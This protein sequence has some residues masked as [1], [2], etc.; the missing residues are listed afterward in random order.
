VRSARV[1]IDRPQPS[2]FV[3]NDDAKPKAS[4]KLDMK[5]GTRLS[6]RQI[7]GIVH[8]TAGAIAGLSPDRVEIMDGSGLLTAKNGDGGAM[9]AQTTLD[10]EAARETYL[11]R[12][13]QDLLDAT[14]GPGRSSVKVSL[15]MDF[16]KRSTATSDPTKSVM[17]RENTTTTD[18]KTPVLPSGGVVGTAPNVEGDGAGGGGKTAMGSKTK[19]EVKNEYVVG[20][21]T[22]TQEDEVGRIKG[23]TVSILLDYKTVKEPKKDDK[24]NPTKEMEEKRIEYTEAERKRFSDLVLN[25]IG[26]NAAKGLAAGSGEAA[27]VVESR[28]SVSVQSMELWREPPEETVVQAGVSLLGNQIKWLDFAG[29][30][31]VGIVALGFLMVAR[32]Q[33][34]RSHKAWSDAEAR[35]R[36]QAE[37]EAARRKT[38]EAAESESENTEIDDQK[39]RSRR[40]ELKDKIRKQVNDDPSTAAQVVRKWLYENA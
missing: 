1:L 14:V 28:F 19:E 20:K 9:M 39:S 13:A 5:M 27:N 37:A 40:Q 8:L 25:A 29:Y 10:A 3:G 36:A 18:E 6:E 26:Y 17:L 31:L 23:M 2:P 30:G 24:G 33:L 38:L 21:S 16:T 12:K 35:S 11:T 32:G 15:K 34:K 4:I 22:V 7:A